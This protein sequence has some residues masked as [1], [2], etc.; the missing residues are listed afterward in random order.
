MSV[1]SQNNSQNAAKVATNES[2]PYPTIDHRDN[3]LPCF[4]T[5]FVT[6]VS[7]ELVSP[8]FVSEDLVASSDEDG[9]V[10]V[11]VVVVVSVSVVSGASGYGLYPL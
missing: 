3:W 5:V 10:S 6:V 4:V 8:W 11:V 7:E 1:N 9:V 2:N